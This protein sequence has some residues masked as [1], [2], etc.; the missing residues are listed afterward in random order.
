MIVY[1]ATEF[2]ILSCFVHS[3]KGRNTKAVL[4]EMATEA[5][6]KDVRMQGEDMYIESV[7]SKGIKLYL[8]EH[9]VI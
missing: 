5:H 8:D 1:F 9:C 6:V 3:Q 7:K 2:D 4:G